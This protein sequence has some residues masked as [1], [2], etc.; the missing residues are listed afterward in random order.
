MYK[1]IISIHS[2]QSNTVQYNVTTITDV[3]SKN[4]NKKSLVEDLLSIGMNYLVCG[5]TKKRHKYRN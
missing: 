5:K 2:I 3:Q 1:I 4:N